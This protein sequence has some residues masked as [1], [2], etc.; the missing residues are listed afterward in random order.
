MALSLPL[1]DGE[2]SEKMQS[3]SQTQVHKHKIFSVTSSSESQR[4]CS[5]MSDSISCDLL[6]PNTEL[7]NRQCHP[8]LQLESCLPHSTFVYSGMMEDV[9]DDIDDNV[10]CQTATNLQ[11]YNQCGKS[12]Q[13]AMSHTESP[14]STCVSKD[15]M[16]TI[17]ETR[18][19]RDVV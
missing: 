6:S 16:S 19:P 2:I 11:S 12:H 5:N 9:A 8:P 4:L 15:E 10:F 13:V 7:Y 18:T 17:S 14:L 1:T 3:L